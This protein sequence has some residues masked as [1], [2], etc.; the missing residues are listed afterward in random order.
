MDILLPPA[1]WLASPSSLMV[2]PM[3]VK[4]QGS[5]DQELKDAA[6]RHEASGAYIVIRTN[7]ECE[8]APV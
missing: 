8:E 7:S 3:L 4:D 6:R 5:H 2:L 1:S